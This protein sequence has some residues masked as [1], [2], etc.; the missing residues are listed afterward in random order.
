LSFT[1]KGGGDAEFQ[2]RPAF[3]GEAAMMRAIVV[4]SVMSLTVSSVALAKEGFVDLFPND[5]ALQQSASLAA[6]IPGGCWQ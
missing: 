4:F 2:E 6:A 3:F 5:A 1:K